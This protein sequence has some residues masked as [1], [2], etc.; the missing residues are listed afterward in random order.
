MSSSKNQGAGQYEDQKHKEEREQ[1]LKDWH[2]CLEDG[3]KLQNK[4]LRKD[5]W[6]EF[7]SGQPALETKNLKEANDRQTAI[8]NSM[9]S[10]SQNQQTGHNSKGKGKADTKDS[11]GKTYEEAKADIDRLFNEPISLA[12]ELLN[13][14]ENEA[15]PTR[16]AGHS[17]ERDCMRKVEQRRKELNSFYREKARKLKDLE[18]SQK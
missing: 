12:E 11:K 3:V 13:E 1:A 10:S 14:A 15:A 5:H 9:M 6:A 7:K 8:I 2:L 4:T 17:F 16:G 18:K